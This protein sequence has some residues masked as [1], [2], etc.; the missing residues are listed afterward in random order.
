M[1]DEH[2]TDQSRGKAYLDRRAE[3]AEKAMTG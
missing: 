3:E 2:V 1:G